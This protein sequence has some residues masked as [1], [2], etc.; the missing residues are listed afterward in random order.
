MIRKY[1]DNGL[2]RGVVAC[3]QGPHISHLFFADNN[4]IFCQATIEQCNHLDHILTT[5]KH[6]S[7]Q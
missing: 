7:G 6:A 2:L 4:I 5:Y 1:V 3:P